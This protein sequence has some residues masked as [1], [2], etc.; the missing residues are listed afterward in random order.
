MGFTME[1]SLEEVSLFEFGEGLIA[2]LISSGFKVPNE[3]RD[4][5]EFFYELKKE[6]R[7]EKPEFFK[8]LM[9]DWDGP[10]PKS[11]VLSE[12]F[13]ALNVIYLARSPYGK[14]VMDEG[15]ITQWIMQI[16]GSSLDL[17]CYFD[18]SA[19]KAKGYFVH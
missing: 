18:Y 19:K 9:F 4:W 2:T 3:N 17:Q 7:D 5:H 1:T 13:N 12:F 14:I 16:K 8:N 6:K 11:P 10:S 15:V